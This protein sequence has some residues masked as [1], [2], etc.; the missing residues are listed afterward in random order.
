MSVSYLVFKTN[1]LVSLLFTFV[2]NL[3]YIVFL[4]TSFFTTFLSLPKS[5]GTGL[6]LSISNLSSLVFKLAK[7]DFSAKLEVS[8]PVAFLILNQFLLHN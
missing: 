4:I 1:S 3:F 6:D 2:T 5:T 8:I 7:F